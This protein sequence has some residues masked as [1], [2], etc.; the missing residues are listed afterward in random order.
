MG[1]ELK[2]DLD[3]NLRIWQK[4]TT[5]EIDARRRVYRHLPY[6]HQRGEYNTRIQEKQVNGDVTLDLGRQP[7]NAEI[8][9]P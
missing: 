7:D 1:N 6:Y 2:K 9:G 8:I 5:R 4:S 3:P